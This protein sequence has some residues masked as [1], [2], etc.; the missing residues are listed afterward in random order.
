MPFTIVRQDLT[1]MEVDA[2]VNAASVTL[3]RGGGVGGAIFRAAGSKELEAACRELA[4]IKVGEAVITPGFALP[5]KYVIHTSGPV[6]RDGHSG[7]EEKL[8]LSYLNSLKRAVENQCESIAFPLI[9]SGVYGYP[10]KQAVQVAMSA[11]QDFLEDHDLDIYLA[12]YDRAAFAVSERLLGSVTDYLDATYVEED[13]EKRRRGRNQRD[14]AEKL[15]ELPVS[16]QS[17]MESGARLPLED[18]VGNLDEAFSET[19]L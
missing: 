15:Q 11:I 19:L 1:K 5:A 4:P 10:K 6:Y 3:E 12:V 18:L 8:R 2:I 14:V 17:V 9:S 16:Y 13:L 7:E